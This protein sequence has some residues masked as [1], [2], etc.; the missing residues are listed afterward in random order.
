MS[1]IGDMI[2]VSSGRYLF[3]VAVIA[4]LVGGVLVF[5]LERLVVWVFT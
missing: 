2:A 1:D 4:F 5:A 3:K